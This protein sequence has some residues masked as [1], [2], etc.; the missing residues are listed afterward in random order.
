MENEWFTYVN[1]DVNAAFWSVV[2]FDADN[3]SEFFSRVERELGWWSAI[4]QF[5]HLSDFGLE[6][7]DDFEADWRQVESWEGYIWLTTQDPNG[8]K[9]HSF[10]VVKN[11]GTRIGCALI[12]S[13]HRIMEDALIA[14]TSKTGKEHVA[15]RYVRW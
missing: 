11:D 12:V 4:G 7:F 3:A 15:T 6:L 1:M 2:D 9:T 8:C 10:H 5:Q 14:T 13:N